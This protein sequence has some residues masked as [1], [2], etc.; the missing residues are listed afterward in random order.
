MRTYFSCLCDVRNRYFRQ[1]FIKY[2]TKNTLFSDYVGSITFICTFPS[3]YNKTKMAIS[4]IYF[5]MNIGQPHLTVK[6]GN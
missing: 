5:A 1:R 4:V 6:C 3:K 2:L